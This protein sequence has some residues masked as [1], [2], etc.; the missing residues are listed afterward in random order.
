[1][2]VVRLFAF[3]GGVPETSAVPA[4]GMGCSRVVGLQ[5]RLSLECERWRLLDCE[6]LWVRDARSEATWR[7]SSSIHFYF[8]GF[9]L[10]CRVGD[11]RYNG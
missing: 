4:C 9:A 11:A 7:E 2:A 5:R 6:T 8:P 10:G 3:S 1:M